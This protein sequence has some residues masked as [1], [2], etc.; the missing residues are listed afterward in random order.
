MERDPMIA[1]IGLREAATPA[2]VLDALAR[3]G[4][5]A[6]RH[7]AV[8]APK[9]RHPAIASLTRLGYTVTPIPPEALDRPTLTD[10]RHARAAFGTGSVAEA[11]ALAAIPGARLLGPRAVSAD[12]LATAAIATGDPE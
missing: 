10:S 4:G 2:S 7:L 12:R 1:G 8:P 6:L 3:A 11:C 9:V 5:A